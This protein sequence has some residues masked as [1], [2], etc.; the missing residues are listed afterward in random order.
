[1]RDA[2]LGKRIADKLAQVWL[3]SG[4]NLWVLVHI[5]IQNQP[6]PDFAKRM[7]TYNYRIFDR[8]DRQ[9][10]SLA[11]LSDEQADWQPTQ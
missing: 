11:V 4:E 8:Y 6:K 3:N 5:E 7:Y 2:E 9:V 10:A 1:M